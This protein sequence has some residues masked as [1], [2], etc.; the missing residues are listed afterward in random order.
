M[1]RA[2]AG[3]ARKEIE[4]QAAQPAEGAPPGTAETSVSSKATK[5][6]AEDDQAAE[7]DSKRSKTEHE[8]TAPEQPD[9]APSQPVASNSTAPIKRDRENTTVIVGGLPPSAGEDDLKRLF[10]DVRLFIVDG[11]IAISLNC[12]VD[13]GQCGEIREVTVFAKPEQTYATVEFFSRVCFN[14][15][16]TFTSASADFQTA[17]KPQDAVLA[18]LTKD[19]KQIQGSE[20]TVE[21]VWQATLYVTNFPESVDDAEMKK[22]FEP[23][24]SRQTHP[25]EELMASGSGC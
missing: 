6:P 1:A 25:W 22:F 4:T 20:L 17:V 5:R 24:R 23:V 9:A 3:E 19:K 11:S 13:F 10:G 12:A 7:P 21:K 14:P 8:P 2:Q 16:E 18:G 15:G